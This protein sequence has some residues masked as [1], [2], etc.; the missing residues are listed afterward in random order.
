MVVGSN[1]AKNEFN[2]LFSNLSFGMNM[3]GQCNLSCQ[4]RQ[5]SGLRDN[6]IMCSSFWLVCVVCMH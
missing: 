4:E 6:Q 5:P 3:K 2:Y 1:L